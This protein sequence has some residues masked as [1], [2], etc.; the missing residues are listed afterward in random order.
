[1]A[2]K[3]RH[4][5]RYNWYFSCSLQT[6]ILSEKVM[7]GGV[8]QKMKEWYKQKHWN[9]MLFS[10][11]FRNVS[12]LSPPSFLCPLRA[13]GKNVP[14]MWLFSAMYIVIYSRP[15]GSSSRAA[16]GNELQLSNANNHT[17]LVGLL[18]RWNKFIYVWSTCNS[19]MQKN[20]TQYPV[21]KDRGKETIERLITQ[22]HW[23]YVCE[24]GRMLRNQ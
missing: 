15:A 11:P 6:R 8:H 2:G 13:E 12:S 4:N 23:C 7:G 17:Y 19:E 9:S 22:L 21:R 14:S 20:C 24:T 18:K 5:F 3:I 10:P 1:M 16:I